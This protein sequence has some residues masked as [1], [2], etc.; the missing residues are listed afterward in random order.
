MSRPSRGQGFT[1]LE[2]ALVSAMVAVA[3]GLLLPGLQHARAQE[4]SRTCQN[5]LRQMAIGAHNYYDTY[6]R[7][8]PGM[9]SQYVG[10]LIYLLPFVNQDILYKNFS[11]DPQYSLYW[12]N[13][14]NRPP[15]DGTDDIPR[16]PDVY[17]CEWE[18]STFLCPD[19]PQPD[20]TVTALMIPH[21]GTPGVDYQA[22][23]GL[24][25]GHL[26][27][28]SPGR[29]VMARSHYLGMAGDWRTDDPYS[30][31]YRGIFTYNSRTRFTDITDGA[32]N[33]I[34]YA[35]AWGGFVDWAGASGVPSGWSTGSRSVGFNYSA[36]GTCP[37]PDNPNCD[38]NSF[39]LSFGT[40]G[41]L[42]LMHSTNGPVLGF[43]VAMADGSARTLRG[44]VD[45]GV[46]EAMS[47]ISDGE[48]NPPG[49]EPTAC[50]AWV[51]Y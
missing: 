16:P 29:L 32:S 19:G 21:Y 38:L 20:E 17:G 40:F 10:G 30:G 24:D 15:T 35:E 18:V 9:D 25:D 31:K 36:F 49:L 5:N 33:T 42:H 2:L 14:Y 1:R 27:T 13:P 44:D 26:F 46:W 6:T 48:I 41:A 12:Q 51:D 47:G 22:D 34:M 7:L 39:G 28:G 23:D 11:F 8:M 45:F 50:G 3:V 4:R 43:N 37:S